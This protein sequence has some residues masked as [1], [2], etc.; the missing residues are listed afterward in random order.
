ML[1]RMRNAALYSSVHSFS[2]D[3][4]L[5]AAAINFDVLG[6]PVVVA[7]LLQFLLDYSCY[8]QHEENSWGK[9]NLAGTP[10][11]YSKLECMEIAT[12]KGLLLLR[13]AV[14]SLWIV[15]NVMMISW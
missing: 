8:L 2:V 10:R 14:V 11:S 12:F 1:A 13:H 15:G 9:C 5:P 7:C 3:L 6:V 4:L